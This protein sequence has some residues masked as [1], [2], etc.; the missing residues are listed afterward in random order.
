MITGFLLIW[1]VTGF[2]FGVYCCYREG[3][4]TVGDAVALCTAWP[5]IGVFVI[6]ARI[7]KE[8]SNSVVWRRK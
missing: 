7:Y 4:C 8:F 2:L 1:C 3:V 5:S 6:T